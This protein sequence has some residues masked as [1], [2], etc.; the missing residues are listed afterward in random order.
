MPCKTYPP[1]SVWCSMGSLPSTTP[2]KAWGSAFRYPVAAYATSN[3]TACPSSKP[4]SCPREIQNHSLLS[5]RRCNMTI[6]NKT[7]YVTMTLSGPNDTT[8]SVRLNN[9]K[10]TAVDADVYA[11]ATAVA[12]LL[13]YPLESSLRVER[14]EM[15]E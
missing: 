15:T 10:P 13:A 6:V 4:I 12:D 2:K 9:V 7:G 14:A 1:K 5:E 8:L 11:V 3:K